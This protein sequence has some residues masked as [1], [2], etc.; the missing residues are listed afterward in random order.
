MKTK[1]NQIIVYFLIVVLTLFITTGVV[2][3]G[4]KTTIS[5]PPLLS[6]DIEPASPAN[7]GIGATLSFTATGHY[8]DGTILILTPEAIWSSDNNG[9][10]TIGSNGLATGVAVGTTNIKVTLEGITSPSV[11]ITVIPVSFIAVTP[12][13]P[14]K[15]NVGAT[16]QFTATAT[17]SDGSTADVSSKVTW[18]SDTPANAVIDYNGLATGEATGNTNI[19]AALSG[20]T[21]PAVVLTVVVPVTTTTTTVP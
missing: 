3:C 7:V 4:S 6:I 20:V 9:I 12:S 19:T 1:S 15:L 10:A 11:V 14:A 5:L 13:A 8:A 16:Q 21:S 2:A 17:Y 18:S